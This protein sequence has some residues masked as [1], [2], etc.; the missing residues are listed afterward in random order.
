MSVHHRQAHDSIPGGGFGVSFVNEFRL[1]QH[2]QSY[3]HLRKACS[4]LRQ[5]SPPPI[6]IIPCPHPKSPATLRLIGRRIVVHGQHHACGVPTAKMP[7]K[8]KTSSPAPVQS[9]IARADLHNPTVPRVLAWRLG[10][11][12]DRHLAYLARVRSGK[13]GVLS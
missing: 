9:L 5:S 4:C 7:I 6:D 11:H 1:R 8:P 13:L 10:P 3:P 2:C 12:D